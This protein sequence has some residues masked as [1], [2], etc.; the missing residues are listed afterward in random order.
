MFL[1]GREGRRR[2][3]LRGGQPGRGA[4]EGMAGVAVFMLLLYYFPQRRT[5]RVIFC[6]ALGEDWFSQVSGF[7]GVGWRALVRVC[8]C[9]QSASRFVARSLDSGLW[10][11]HSF[12]GGKKAERKG[13]RKY[14][15]SCR[16]WSIVWMDCL[17]WIVDWLTRA[18]AKRPK[19]E[20]GIDTRDFFFVSVPRRERRS[21]T[22]RRPTCR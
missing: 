9:G 11:G 1:S 16:G 7:F 21:S 14:S 19:K 18:S 8:F 15:W 6:F 5:D 12:F 10:R 3:A 2:V 17:D 13:G 4:S 20:N 22:G